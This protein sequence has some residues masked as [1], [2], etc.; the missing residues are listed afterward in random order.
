[1]SNLATASAQNKRRANRLSA[2]LSDFHDRECEHGR[3]CT[4]PDIKHGRCIDCGQ[5]TEQRTVRI[6]EG[7][8]KRKLP[9]VCNEHVFRPIPSV[10]RRQEELRAQRTAGDWEKVSDPV[11]TDSIQGNHMPEQYDSASRRAVRAFVDA[12]FDV[13]AVPNQDV[14]TLSQTI[15][16]LGLD[17]QVYAET[18]NGETILRRTS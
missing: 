7:T 6:E 15:R 5:Y 11:A 12:G 17:A 1:M 9:F 13:A 10:V 4:R 18:R 16:T 2:L 14:M 3:R 8:L